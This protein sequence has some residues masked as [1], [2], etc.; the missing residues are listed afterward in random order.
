MKLN[1]LIFNIDHWYMEFLI[2]MLND[3][4][5]AKRLAQDLSNGLKATETFVSFWH[6][7]Q[8]N[9]LCI[10]CKMWLKKSA[11]KFVLLPV[12]LINLKVSLFFLLSRISSSFLF[13][14]GYSQLLQWTTIK[15]WKKR[16]PFLK[17]GKRRVWFFRYLTTF[18]YLFF[19]FA[20][21]TF[22]SFLSTFVLFF[23]IW[24]A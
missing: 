21:F 13:D 19:F 2:D 1:T 24:L 12:S 8:R 15:P 14:S 6:C 17:V 4:W 5:A 7:K 3:H 18:D 9:C 22:F 10:T 23:F 16:N 11:I 20:V